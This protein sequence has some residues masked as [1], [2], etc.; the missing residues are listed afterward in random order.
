[1][2]LWIIGIVLLYL[3]G[4]SLLRILF[5]K[6]YDWSTSSTFLITGAA[7]GIGKKVV[8]LLLKRNQNV[9]AADINIKGLEENAKEWKTSNVLIVQLDVTQ[10]KQWEEVYQKGI[11]QFGGIDVHMNIAGFLKAGPIQNLSDLDVERHVDVN[12][13]GVIFGTRAAVNHMMKKK[14]GFILNISSMASL[15]PI[16]GLGIYAATKSAVRSF[17]LTAAREYKEF[18]INITTV[19]PDAVRTPM[20]DIQRDVPEASLTFSSRILEVDEIVSVMLDDALVYQ[21]EE[22]WYPYSR[23]LLAKF[24]DVMFASPLLQLI[25]KPL[26]SKGMQAQNTYVPSTERKKVE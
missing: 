9:I 18:G 26:L 8:E 21:P 10:P 7:S 3:L 19:A 24:A 2:W 23:G 6:R 22:I 17:S 1:M 12:V 11:T 20:V 16:R 5:P 15:V 4:P 25:Q 13:K 14:K